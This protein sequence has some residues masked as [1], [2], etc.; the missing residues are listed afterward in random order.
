MHMYVCACGGAQADAENHPP[1]LFRL[2]HAGGISQ[3]N[4]ELTN[5]G[6]FASQLAL[7]ISGH[8]AHPAFMRVS[9]DPNSDS[10][11]A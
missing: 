3:S 11:H 4:P 5:M 1:P 2:I 9:C 7:G 10:P 8:H 6:S